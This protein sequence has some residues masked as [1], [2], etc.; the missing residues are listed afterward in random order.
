M[1]QY[2]I[3]VDDEIL[4]GLFTGDKGMS[5][6]LEPVL[7]QV[8]NAQASEQLQAEPYE[9][10]KERQGFRQ[11]QPSQST[12]YPRWHAHIARATAEK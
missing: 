12:H 2:S 6:L 7:N 5:Q 10:A 8:L 11:R 1:A 3:T 9:R 4:K